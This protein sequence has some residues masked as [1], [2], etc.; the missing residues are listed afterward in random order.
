MENLENYTREDLTIGTGTAQWG[1]LLSFIPFLVLF[2]IPFFFVYGNTIHIEFQ[3]Q[4]QENGGGLL[5]WIVIGSFLVGVI[6]H[7]LIHGLTWA[8]FA[9]NGMKS[10]K[11]GIIWKWLTPYCHCKEPLS[12]KHYILGAV[13]PGII[14]GILPSIV[15]VITGNILWFMWGMMF[16][17]AAGGDFMI[18]NLLRKQPLNCF[19]KDHPTKVGCYIY[20]PVNG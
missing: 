13:M 10:M 8:A 17:L 2:G 11:F 6:V 9:K 3:A 18:I 14:L 16:T 4:L 15:A 5:F 20:K 1:A 12:V 7:E 19:I